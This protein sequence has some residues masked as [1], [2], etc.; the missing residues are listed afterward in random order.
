MNKKKKK[1]NCII[2][3]SMHNQLKTMVIKYPLSAQNIVVKLS[4]RGYNSSRHTNCCHNKTHQMLNQTTQNPRFKNS[5]NQQFHQN[6]R[7]SDSIIE[8]NTKHAQK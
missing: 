4:L 2:R 1:K 8:K 3:K 6:L 5:H 7:S